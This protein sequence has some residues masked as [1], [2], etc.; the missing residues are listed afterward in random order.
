MSQNSIL[1]RNGVYE[2]EMSLDAMND[3]QL[4]ILYQNGDAK[5]FDELFKRLSP[6]VFGFLSKRL[7]NHETVADLSQET[8]VKFHKTKHLYNKSLPVLPWLFTITKSV[9]LDHLK[10]K[11]LVMVDDYDLST[12]PQP[13]LVLVNGEKDPTQFLNQLPDQQNIALHLR[14]IE[15]HSF[16][17][18][19]KSLQTSPENARQIV[20]RGIKRLKEL[21][22]GDANE[23]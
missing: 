6:K 11:N 5:A 7:K 19:S 4:M 18:I 20:S 14:Y 21:F 13:Q 16:E 8:F 9:L 15:E 17:D 23:K 12:I 22:N 3:E 1:G 10:K 2:G